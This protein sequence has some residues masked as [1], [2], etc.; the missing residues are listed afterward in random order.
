MFARAERTDA[1]PTAMSRFKVTVHTAFEQNP[2]AQM[3]DDGS[4]DVSINEQSYQL[5]CG[6]SNLDS[7]QVSTH[8][9]PSVSPSP[10]QPQSV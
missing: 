8:N 7:S 5:A 4:P 6:P 1:T 2:T 10:P 3:S 9:L